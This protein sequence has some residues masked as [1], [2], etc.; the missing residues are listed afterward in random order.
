MVKTDSWVLVAIDSI[1]INRYLKMSA[2]PALQ[3]AMESREDDGQSN[4]SEWRLMNEGRFDTIKGATSTL[5]PVS[6]RR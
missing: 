1:N 2:C 4:A 6:V 3:I 5:R